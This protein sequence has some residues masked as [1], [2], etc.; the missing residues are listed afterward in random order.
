[1]GLRKCRRPG[2][3]GLYVLNWKPLCLRIGPAEAGV[4]AVTS[5]VDDEALVDSVLVA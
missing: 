3:R 2:V 1:M 5:A 4:N